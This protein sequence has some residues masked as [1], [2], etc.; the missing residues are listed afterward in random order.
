[1]YHR[2]PSGSQCSSV[3]LCFFSS[4]SVV[5]PIIHFYVSINPKCCQGICAT[6]VFQCSASSCSKCRINLIN[7]PKYSKVFYSTTYIINTEQFKAI[8]LYSYIGRRK[9]YLG[10]TA[11]HYIVRYFSLYMRS[12][13]PQDPLPFPQG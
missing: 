1:M 11:K 13:L 8:Q 9:I 6:L 4:P 2:E 10:N 12:F 7:S 5:C 3:C